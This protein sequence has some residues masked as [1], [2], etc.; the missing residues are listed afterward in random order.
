MT[1]KRSKFFALPVLAFLALLS[2]PNAA[3]AQ[4][5]VKGLDAEKGSVELEY[6]GDYNFG[7]PKRG[8]QKAEP[9]PPAEFLFD[10]NE[11][12]RQR[13]SFELGMGLTDWLQIS[14]G[15]ELEQERIDDPDTLS[16]ANSFG[17]LKA[18]SIQMEGTV[19]V[20]PEKPNGIGLG[21]YGQLEPAIQ[22]GDANHFSVGP[23][24]TASQGPWSVALN[25]WIGHLY[26]GE[27]D[28]ANGEFR[29]ERW[30][31]MPSTIRS[32]LPSKATASSIA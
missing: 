4:F 26:G 24:I 23:I 1:T 19:V 27:S 25:P 6:Q 14:V 7:P 15:V 18:T 11:V 17:D 29:D 32:L 10:E 13:H 9:G 16:Q 30:R 20:I 5:E 3:R 12:N 22:E 2:F 8:I 31:H 28:P 21:L